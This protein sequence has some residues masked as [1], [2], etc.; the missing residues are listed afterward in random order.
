M[1]VIAPHPVGGVE[2]FMHDQDQGLKE[3]VELG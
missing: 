2:L 1:L 3:K